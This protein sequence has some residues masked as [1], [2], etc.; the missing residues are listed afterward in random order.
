[1]MKDIGKMCAVNRGAGVRRFLLLLL[2]AVCSTYGWAQG[3][4]SGKVVDATGEPVIGA[5]VMVKG[6]STGAVTDIDGNFSIPNAP[7]NGNLEISYI[8]FK[9]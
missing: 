4:V 8:G 6:T 7:K 9:T 1:M 3:T 5:S 2:L